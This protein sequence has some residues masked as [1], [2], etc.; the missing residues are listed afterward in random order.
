ML[1]LFVF[2][3]IAGITT[4]LS[5]C[6]LPVLPVLLTAS[7]TK[8]KM[9][10][11][12][13]V[14]GLVISFTFFTL[15]LSYIIDATGL[16]PNILRYAAIAIIAF[17][18]LVMVFP[19]LSN[20]FARSTASVAELGSNLQAHSAKAG[21][22]FW[23]GFIIGAALGLVWTP[24]AG[25]ILAAIAS[26]AAF[27]SISTEVILLTL[28]YSAGAAL[29]ML[30]II[31]GGQTAL[32]SSKFLAAHSEAIRKTFG[33]L[34]ILTAFF[35]ASGLDLAF[36][37]MYLSKLPILQ[38][39]DIDY[40]KRQLKNLK[41]NSEFPAHGPIAA[42]ARNINASQLPAL[43]GTPEL[44]GIDGWLNSGPLTMEQLRGK[45]VLIDFWTYSCINCLRTLPYL[46]RWYNT[47][48]DKGFVV[49][50]VHTPEFQ[51]EK[52]KGNV[53]AAVK[54]LHITYPVALDSHYFT[55]NA[56]DNMYWPAHYL[57]DQTGIIRQ[58]HYGE[59]GYV[60]TEND[61]RSLLGLAPIAEKEEQKKYRPVTP[62]TY[63]GY[64]RADRYV[65]EIKPM[66]NLV[67]DYSYKGP[68]DS[69]KVGLKGLW[70]IESE[71]ITSKSPD[72]QLDLNF[73]ATRVYLVLGGK[74]QEPIKVMLDDKPLPKEY[75][76]DDM[77]GQGEIY[78]R[79]PR[80]YDMLNLHGQYGRHKL[81]LI[82]PTG[83]SAY[84]FTFG[85]EP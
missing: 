63:L 44:T 30:L 6:T 48:K 45:V 40:V 76:S 38:V 74:S 50:G 65:D 70:L 49:I 60:E 24:C 57:V 41:K 12:G 21:K 79:E 16:P 55:W 47:Y 27:H 23:G 20:W 2:A 31:Y 3:F 66:L 77:N 42:Q 71:N 4:I 58:I 68:L 84:A 51:F 52:D 34:T 69:N 17:F 14:L 39:E 13:I 64:Y 54:H 73:L 18:G 83:I 61:I 1:I 8:G 11:I 22:G 56:F 5:P 46:E 59:G 19:S 72:S 10:P 9:R 28:S 15:A 29:P 53:E 25:P 32:K 35:L 26:L 43:A 67:Y 33:V 80:K 7:V 85:D 78:V 37:Q 75:Y 36:E 81:T 82:I 62:E